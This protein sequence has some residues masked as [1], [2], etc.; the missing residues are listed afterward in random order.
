LINELKLLAKKDIPYQTQLKMFVAE[1]AE[2]EIKRYS[3]KTV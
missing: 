1:R 2:K 3:Q